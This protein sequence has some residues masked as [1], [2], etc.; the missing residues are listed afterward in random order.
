MLMLHQNEEKYGLHYTTNHTDKMKYLCSVSTACCCNDNCLKRRNI[1]GSIC[2]KCYAMTMAKR[3]DALR[4][5]LVKNTEVLT[6]VIIPKKDLPIL[7]SESGLFRFEAFGD[8]INEIQ[9]VNYF[10]M[11]AAN[12]GIHCA[13]WTKNLWIIEKAMKEYGIKKPRNLQIIGSSYFINKS[14]A[15]FYKRYDFI[16]NVFTVYD[17]KYAAA[18][19]INIT[20]GA[21]ACATC[22]K[23]YTGKH[24]NYEI[25][26]LLK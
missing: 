15:A 11:A 25:N 18:H 7:Y 5:K 4:E 6:T 22:R 14:M 26:E 3:F 23:C 21:R 24:N 10:N 17:K 16:D 13:L 12:K 8:L 2:E 1:P 20:C 9:V 19:N